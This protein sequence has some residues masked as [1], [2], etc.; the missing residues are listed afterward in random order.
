M[1]EQVY[2]QSQLHQEKM[3][4][5]FNKHSNKEEFQLGDLVLKWDMRNEY[6]GNHEKFDNVWTDPFKIGAYRG[7]NAYFL[8]ELNGESIGWGPVNG[9]F[10]KHYLMK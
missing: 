7:N 4:K 3:K 6:K 1:R 9:R 8:E 2:N 10:L 5:S